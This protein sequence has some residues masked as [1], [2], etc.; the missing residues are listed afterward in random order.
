MALFNAPNPYGSYFDF[1]S[2]YGTSIDPTPS[3]WRQQYPDLG[4][5]LSSGL[6]TAIGSPG[7][8]YNPSEREFLENR[9]RDIA[10][11]QFLDRAIKDD[12]R[13][14]TIANMLLDG[15]Y[16]SD[17][18]AKAKAVARAGGP[19]A[20]AGIIGTLM[21]TPGLSGYFGGS[22]RSL[23][24]G[25]LAAA[26]S[27]LTMNGYGIYGDKGLNMQF[28]DNLLKQVNSKF[29]ASNGN[30]ILSM[31][32]GL[33][34]DQMGGLMI[35]AA[36]Q[37]A[38]SGLDMGHLEKLDKAGNNVK[39]VANDSTVTKITEF[40][41]YASKALGNLIDVY[42]D[43]SSGE[44][45]QKAQRITG[46]DL[47]RLD[48]A[49]VMSDRLQR[50]RDTAR[51]AGFDTQ[52]MFDMS[53]R[54]DDYGQQLGLRPELSGS[55]TALAAQSGARAF[56]A[57]QQNTSD[58]YTNSISPME[59][60]QSDLRDLAGMS[61]DP[62]GARL[63]ALELAIKN[64]GVS[65]AKASWLRAQAAGLPANANGSSQLDAL[66]QRELGVS[67][68]GLIRGYGG[69]AALQ[70]QLSPA[71]QEN[72]AKMLAQNIRPRQ[73]QLISDLIYRGGIMPT[74]SSGTQMGAMRD[75]LSN[76]DNQ[77]IEKLL[78]GNGNISDTLRKD[79]FTEDET[80]RLRQ[81]IETI[82]DMGANGMTAYRNARGAIQANEL[83]RT[84][85]PTSLQR[86]NA[87]MDLAAD[88]LPDDVRGGMLGNHF[89]E[90]M[91]D[92]YSGNDPVSRL[93]WINAVT[94]ER[95]AGVQEKISIDFNSFLTG[96]DG[97]LDMDKWR[98]NA[99][100]WRKGLGRTEEGQAMIQKYHLQDITDDE[101][102]L[103]ESS[104]DYQHKLLEQFYND[105]RD[106]YQLQHN[107]SGFD[108]F[109]T[110]NGTN[111]V[112][113]TKSDSERKQKYGDVGQ[114][115]LERSKQLDGTDATVMAQNA[116]IL[117]QGQIYK[118][119]KDHALD[120]N[121]WRLKGATTEEQAAASRRLEQDLLR[122]IR[123]GVQNPSDDYLAK[124]AKTQVGGT[125]L[126][127]LKDRETAI[128]GLAG[129]EYYDK[130]KDELE[131]IKTAEAQLKK[132]TGSAKGMD[133]SAA[134]PAKGAGTFRLEGNL[135]L[136]N[137]GGQSILKLDDVTASPR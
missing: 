69:P 105:M 71:Q 76:L 111:L 107:M 123:S 61:R 95:V 43:I 24:L 115:A 59:A 29:Y 1:R 36:S 129:T 121:V 4:A 25:S 21:N 109:P 27:G 72:Y 104:R 55:F 20:Y 133:K 137:Q 79:G 22:A 82:R 3:A 13:T 91:L 18:K 62:L 130:Y 45:L 47:S 12:P 93:Q 124:V 90:G 89:F 44:L 117:L 98:R 106:P 135:V 126:S 125:L 38:F 97:H 94:P 81:S 57:R 35:S 134:N 119:G 63:S 32:S 112:F 28:A 41:K 70:Q 33:N 42:G 99:I 86:R 67:L 7:E 46:L 16:G 31:T 75:I 88:E 92:K 10:Y 136:Q 54:L 50:L 9:R 60:M 26:T 39:F 77:T 96:P 8:G 30:P 68:P 120:P 103:S 132:D 84:Y 113:A 80:A 65:D 14:R 74:G 108:L 78:A 2:A 53:A 85:T 49:K 48:N 56:R 118:M 127:D 101:N 5:P 66:A 131:R 34:R 58:F 23:A 11:Q 100:A 37:G 122:S 19:D 116:D 51:A 110:K 128:E 102:G 17:A 52:S 40:M 15:V 87:Y 83:T 64:A 6:S 114:L 73:Q